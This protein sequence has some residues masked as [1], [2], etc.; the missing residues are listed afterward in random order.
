KFTSGGE[1][2]IRINSQA[3]ADGVSTLLFSVT[4]TGIGIAPEVQSRLFTAFSQADTSTTRRY[5]GTGLG[6]AI[7]KRLVAMM[8][9]EIG[10]KSEVG[11][12]STFWFTGRFPIIAQNS[13]TT[14]AFNRDPFDLRVLVVDDNATNRQ[15]LRHQI[16]SWRMQKGSAAGGHEALQVLRAA[17]ADRRPYDIALLDLEMPEMDG[18]TLAHAIK[19]EPAIAGTRLIALANLG[20]QLSDE[21]MREA[22]IAACL[23]KPIKQSRL[24]DCLVN[25]IGRDTAE[26][27]FT[28]SDAKHQETL[29]AETVAQRQS[30]RILLAEDNL[31]NQKVALGTLKKIGYSADVANNGLEVLDALK[32]TPYQVILLD[33]QMPEMDGFETARHIRKVEAGPA[34][35]CPWP[36]PIKI[37]ALTAIAMQ[38]DREKCLA[39]GM[40]D[41][42]TKP[43]R[44]SEMQAALQ[45]VLRAP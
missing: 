17:I 4:D 16:F 24:L 19:A 27:V 33:C 41:Y 34:G 43:V 7:S 40:D 9:G 35:S 44:P 26:Q 10:I 1:V 37:V 31:V 32:R 14:P 22:G 21:Q 42:I 11:K 12:G 28:K 29:S 8:G 13:P 18:L 6:L 23:V 39:S 5:G 45:R 36:A 30:V 25:V 2:V 38:G 15:I 20:R 3:Q